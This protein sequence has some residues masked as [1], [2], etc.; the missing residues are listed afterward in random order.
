MRTH[1]SLETIEEFL[2]HKRVAMVGLS[3]DEKDFSA[4]LFRELCLKGYDVVPVNPQATEVA[5]RR[6]FARVQEIDPPVEAVLLMTKPEVTERVVED[7]AAAGVRLVWMYRAAGTG[8]V[9]A[10]ALQ[11]CL[12]HGMSVVAGECPFM[13][14]EGTKGVHRFHGWWRK[15]WGSYPQRTG[16][17]AA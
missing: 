8:A 6:C 17:R 15:M 10:K 9:S 12:E 7:C 1:T 3:R 11:F 13:F 16:T 4:A 2:A 5:G 14:L